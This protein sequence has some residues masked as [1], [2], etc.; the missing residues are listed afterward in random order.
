MFDVQVVRQRR[1]SGARRGLQALRR[2]FVLTVGDRNLKLCA[3]PSTSAAAV[4]CIS[5]NNINVRFRDQEEALRAAELMMDTWEIDPLVESS[6]IRPIKSEESSDCTGLAL[7]VQ[8]YVTDRN[9][10]HVVYQ[11]HDHID[12]AVAHA[13]FSFKM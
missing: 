10:R 5:H 12:A 4:L 3:G 6:D 7:L 13:E 8:Q 9:F 1:D 2:S 11:L